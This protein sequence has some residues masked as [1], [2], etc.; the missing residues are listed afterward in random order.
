M[1]I[2]KA[3]PVIPIS[4]SLL[5]SIPAIYYHKQLKGQVVIIEYCNVYLKRNKFIHGS[6]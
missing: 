4:D 6:G 5:I 3:S 1:I 2:V